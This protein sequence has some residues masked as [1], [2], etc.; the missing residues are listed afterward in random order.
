MAHHHHSQR[1]Y[2]P[3]SQPSDS[4][5]NINSIHFD[6]Q[7]PQPPSY[8]Y[9]N[10][11]DFPHHP[12]HV[13]GLAP[14]EGSDGGADLQ[15]NYGLEP[16]RKR[17]KEHDFMESNSK[18]SC[19]EF[20]KPRSVST[21]LGLS[22]ENSRMS[23]VGNSALLSNL[24]NDIDRELLQQDVEID[25][26]LRAE[27]KRL[28]ETIIEKVQATQ[29]ES[30]SII[31]DRVLQKL[32]E[33]EAEIEGINMRNIELEE[34]LEQLAV[35]ADAWQQRASYSENMVAAL[36]FNL[37]QVYAQSRDSKEGCGDSEV[38]DTASCIKGGTIDFHLLSKGNNNMNEMMT[39]KACKVNK[40]NMLLLPCKH[41]CLCKDCESKLS[42]CPQCQSSK[43]IGI[44][45][46]M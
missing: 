39:C 43:F 22:L 2:Q 19:V 45:V 1:H 34:R 17:L 24:G 46:Y 40:V 26:F 35:E 16:E 29:L 14:P 44:E 5:R 7:M 42:F 25:R 33:K 28:R 3:Q 13:V 41:L 27:G 30:I 38:D 18:I 8:S 9:P 32:R 20:M 10:P 4:F 36:K 23:S 11:T 31:E 6:D 12:F 37:E 21:G 15:W